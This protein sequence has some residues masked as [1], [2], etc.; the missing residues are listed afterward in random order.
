MGA[1]GEEVEVLAEVG[2][3][4]EMVAFICAMMFCRRAT[5][6]ASGFIAVGMAVVGVTTGVNVGVAVVGRVVGEDVDAGTG[7]IDGGLVAQVGGTA[8][9]AVVGVC[10]GAHVPDAQSVAEGG[11]LNVDTFRACT[12]SKAPHP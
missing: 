10:V 9:G 3:A 2:D 12:I 7:E 11:S 4:D 5:S 6:A 8:A 1:I